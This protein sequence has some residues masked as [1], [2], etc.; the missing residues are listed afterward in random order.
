MSCAFSSTGRVEVG[1]DEIGERAGRL[2]R[3]D[4]RA[5]LARQL[6]HELDDL[7]GDVA[8]AHRQRLGLDVLG[9]W[10]LELADL[11]ACRY[12]AFWVTA[13]SRMRDQP[14]QD[15]RVVARAVLER[16][17]HARRA[18]DRVQVVEARIVRRRIALREDRD[19]RPRQVVDVLDERDRLLAPH[20]ERRDRAGEQHRVADGKDGQLVAELHVFVGS[21]RHGKRV[22]FIGHGSSFR[23]ERA[24]PATM[25][26]P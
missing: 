18:P 17:E 22:F 13:S 10:L 26:V 25:L 11:R 4:E 5:G 14:L 20:V 16:L 15:Q 21:L 12:G 24:R 8:Q 6:G 3:V 19:D 2:D 1:G 9:A 23:P 7:L